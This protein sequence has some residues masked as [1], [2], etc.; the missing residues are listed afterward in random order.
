MASSI[1]NAKNA[2]GNNIIKNIMLYLHITSLISYFDKF[3]TFT[4]LKI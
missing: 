3:P 4:Y 2:D 1:I